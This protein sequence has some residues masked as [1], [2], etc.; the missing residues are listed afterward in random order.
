MGPK[1]ILISRL[2]RL[3]DDLRHAR[4]VLASDAI[5]DSLKRRLGNDLF[6]SIDDLRRKIDA[7]RQ[8]A[9]DLSESGG[10]DAVLRGKNAW[11]KLDSLEVRA[12][13]QLAETLAVLHG[14]ITRS[15]KRGEAG[16]D[17]ELAELA[18]DLIGELCAPLPDLSWKR[19]T[20]VAGGES[21]ADGTQLIRLRFPLSDIWNLPVAVHEFGHF[22]AT[23]LRVSDAGDA[24]LPFAQ[25]LEQRTRRE[26]NKLWYYLNEFFADIAA[27]YALGPAYGYTCVLL[28]FSPMRA[29]QETDQRHPPDGHRAFVIFETLDRMNR[30]EDSEGELEGPASR[31]R[32]FWSESLVAAG[33]PAEPPAQDVES[34]RGLVQEIYDKVLQ[35]G[36]RHLRYNTLSVAKGLE[37]RLAD[38]TPDDLRRLSL[39]DLLNAAWRKKLAPGVDADHVSKT[40]VKLWRTASRQRGLPGS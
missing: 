36:A 3:D 38:L 12:E 27:T 24:A 14:A 15:R 6:D 30:E 22:L 13:A 7:E 18:D 16:E 29:W 28:R 32:Q 2:A 1:E 9:R 20:Y 40:F 21:F 23:R 19:F 37:S 39:R 34:L 17:E 26:K 11:A 10:E 8:A 35:P 31:L 5:P 33:R 25:I 4:E